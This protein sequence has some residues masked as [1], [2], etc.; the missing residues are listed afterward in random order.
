MPAATLAC[1][2]VGD[3]APQR[4]GGA[5][6]P[7]AGGA[8]A[9]PN[10]AAGASVLQTLKRVGGTVGAVLTSPLVTPAYPACVLAL[11]IYLSAGRLGERLGDRGVVAAAVLGRS[12]S[13]GAVAAAHVLSDSAVAAAH[14]LSDGA[15]AAAHV[16]VQTLW[17]GSEEP[18]DVGGGAVAALAALGVAARLAARRLATWRSQ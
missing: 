16:H 11:G 8:G 1:D 4:I 12:L 10:A 9:S 17:D 18:A 2:V 6:D 7:A 5:S 15:V 3:G 14:V 13:D